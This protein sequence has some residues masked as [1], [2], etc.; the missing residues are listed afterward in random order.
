M[1]AKIACPK[2]GMSN[3]EHG[4]QCLN[5]SEALPPAPAALPAEARPPRPPAEEEVPPFPVIRIRDLSFGRREAVA[6]MADRIVRVRGRFRPT[7]RFCDT[8]DPADLGRVNILSI[9]FAEVQGI[10]TCRR[11][12][13]GEGRHW[14]RY[15]VETIERNVGF[16]VPYRDCRNVNGRLAEALGP[17]FVRNLDR[18]TPAGEWMFLA[19]GPVLL[20]WGLLFFTGTILN[21][22]NLDWVFMT[23]GLLS[24]AL[25]LLWLLLLLRAGYRR[26]R[27]PAR[28]DRAPRLRR[29]RA[30]SGRPPLRS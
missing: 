8:G 21:G 23:A 27:S 13:L 30:A 4:E 9:P 15:S 7:E 20:A 16:R 24:F 22:G 10:C 2:C 14:V 19:A 29:R 3:P 1:G 17:R 12:L 18:V 11:G 6:V 5:C 28:P 26:A 25:S